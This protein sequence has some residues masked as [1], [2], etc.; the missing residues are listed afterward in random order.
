MYTIECQ[1]GPCR[2]VLNSPTP[3][4]NVPYKF[5]QFR[6]L[7]N[8]PVLKLVVAEIPVVAWCKYLGVIFGKNLSFISHN[9]SSRFKGRAINVSLTNQSWVHLKGVAKAH[10]RG[11]QS[12]IGKHSKSHCRPRWHRQAWR[13]S[14]SYH[15]YFS[16]G[17][18]YLTWRI[19]GQCIH[20]NQ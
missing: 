1:C 5:C 19:W 6:G 18:F 13:L 20:M 10:V 17:L 3:K 8:Y 7:H 14:M 4:L 11:A 12:H 15:A 9:K 16:T 2:M